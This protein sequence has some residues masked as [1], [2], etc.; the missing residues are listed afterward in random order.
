M[1]TVPTPVHFSQIITT[2]GPEGPTPTATNFSSYV[3][4]GCYVANSPGNAPIASSGPL[5]MAIFAGKSTGYSTT[6]SQ[7][8]PGSVSVP[9]GSDSVTIEVW[10]GGGGGGAGN[11]LTC[12]CSP[13]RVLL[14][15]GTGGSGG[16]SRYTFSLPSP[17]SSNWGVTNAFNY[18]VG[19][20]GA[21]NSAGTVSSVSSTPFAPFTTLYGGQGTGG[22]NATTCGPGVSGVGYTGSGG[23]AGTVHYAGGT[24]PGGTT[25]YGGAGGAAGRGTSSPGSAGSSGIVRFTWS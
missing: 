8:S 12:P 17:H 24:Y 19:T 13:V 2:F 9:P 6:V 7:T 21:A 18:T 3:R 4:G 5:S 1:A 11:I 16:Y 15:G 22:T 25:P 20:G 10:G 14:S 23:P